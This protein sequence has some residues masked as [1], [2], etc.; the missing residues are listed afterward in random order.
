MIQQNE[1]IIFLL[2]L[3]VLTFILANR[4]R[5][6][7]FPAWRVLVASFCILLLG[8]L[9]T[10]LEDILWRDLLNFAEHISYALSSLL[11]A[12]WCWRV[13]YKGE[14]APP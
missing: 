4:W 1:L 12:F 14:G 6:S 3:G 5:I 11:I 7:R 8:W 13:F 10:I 9:L 2:G